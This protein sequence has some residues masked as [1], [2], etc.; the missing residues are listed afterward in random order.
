MVMDQMVS[1]NKWIPLYGVGGFEQLHND[2]V[3]HEERIERMERVHKEMEEEIHHTNSAG[4][5]G[6]MELEE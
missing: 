1:M 5:Q 4:Y 3:D 2:L 6:R